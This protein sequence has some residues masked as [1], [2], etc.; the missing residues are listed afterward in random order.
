MN[1]DSFGKPQPWMADALC[2]QFDP[3]TFYAEQGYNDITRE[4]K[5]IC[6]QCPV[7]QL[8]LAYALETR[9]E[10]GVWGGLAWYERKRLLRGQR[11]SA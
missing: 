5:R 10:Y 3:D 9:D 11:R 8:C 7:K 4:A 2:L 1:G 6:T